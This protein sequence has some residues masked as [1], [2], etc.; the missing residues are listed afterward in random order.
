MTSLRNALAAIGEPV[1]MPFALRRSFGGRTPNSLRAAMAGMIDPQVG[2]WKK[3]DVALK[4]ANT[5][6]S[7]EAQGVTTDGLAW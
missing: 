6:L 7:E 5:E 4:V 1:V 3:V 2:Q